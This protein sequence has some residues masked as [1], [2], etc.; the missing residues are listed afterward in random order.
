MSISSVS[1][2]LPAVPSIWITQI[3]SK[4]S[5]SAPAAA[6]AAATVDTVAISQ[7]AKQFLSAAAVA[8]PDGLSQPD[9]V[10]QAISV[11]N[12]TDG[13]ASVDDQIQAYALTVN[14]VHGPMTDT[15]HAFDP[16]KAGAMVALV[17]SPFSQHV[18][19]VLNQVDA[20]KEMWSNPTN[21]NQPA[22]ALDR[23]L[24]T[25]NALSATD[26]QIYVSTSNLRLQMM[27]RSPIG[28]AD[29]YRANQG[30]QADVDRALQAIMSD[31]AYAT[32]LGKTTNA[33]AEQVMGLPQNFGN[34]VAD[35]GALAAAAGDQATVTLV[36]LAQGSSGETA[37]WTQEAQAYLAANGP[38]PAPV[39]TASTE[40]D[41]S[42]SF[43]GFGGMSN[44]YGGNQAP[45]GYQA[46]DGKT[47]VAALAATWDTTGKVSVTDQTAAEQTLQENFLFRQNIY[48]PVSIAFNKFANGISPFQQ[49]AD[50]AAANFFWNPAVMTA[51]SGNTDPQPSQTELGLLNALPLEQQ[52]LVF[53]GFGLNVRNRVYEGYKMVYAATLDDWK[54]QLAERA[55]TL[56]AAYLADPA[57]ASAA[58]A[59][60][61][62]TTAVSG[63]TAASI[64]QFNASAKDAAKALSILTAPAS[65]SSNAAIALTVLRSAAK[66]T[67]TVKAANDKSTGDATVSLARSLVR[68]TPSAT[69]KLPAHNT[70][71]KVS[72]TT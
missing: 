17:D 18:Q 6:T 25:F 1:V 41:Y 56:H 58:N 57:S 4:A 22:N 45:A 39:Q 33:V 55:V 51:A 68:E 20:Q 59:T 24:A 67:T 27:G 9:A 71:D 44:A 8:A 37:D 54:T 34:R 43:Y 63:A 21:G 14:F 40:S 60:A 15:S 64:A 53:A 32:A 47:L 23:S 12:T 69:S 28:T 61:S 36:K 10:T 66:A 5:S 72:V 70:G 2:V 62:T 13:S 31:P 48:S 52:Q 3:A 16:S 7:R 50:A 29:D 26:Q 38:P 46:P 65:N 42:G 11:L 19:Q 49:K 30:A 35:L